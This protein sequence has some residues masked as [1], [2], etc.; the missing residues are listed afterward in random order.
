MLL[1]KGARR[2][3]NGQRGILMPFKPL[4]LGWAGKGQLP[5]LVQVE[6]TAHLADIKGQSL[7]AG[8]YANEL[9]LKLLHRFDAHEDLFLGYDLAVHRLAEGTEPGGVLRVF[10]KRLL[11]EIGFALIL[12]HEATTGESIDVSANYA[13]APD[14]GPLD[15]A[16]SG[17]TLGVP[18]SG[19]TLRELADECFSSNRSRAEARRLT[20]NLIQQQ[21]G[22][23]E[24]RSRRVLRQ[25]IHYRRANIPGTDRGNASTAQK[26]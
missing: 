17:D 19:L 12:D 25:V 14:V 9:I 4:L 21:L 15:R 24:L 20:R 7:H 13:Y 23:R 5:I 16:H 10:E 8:L 6:S 11:R 22:G 2:Q 26:Q 18:V 1:A 3:K